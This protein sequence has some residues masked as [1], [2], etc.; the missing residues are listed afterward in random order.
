MITIGTFEQFAVNMRNDVA[1][2]ERLS[3]LRD[4]I[5]A[6]L[7][8]VGDVYPSENFAYATE[9]VDAAENLSAWLDSEVKDI[10]ARVDENYRNFQREIAIEQGLIED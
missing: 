6:T 4:K 3:A 5:D 8:E 7:K 2:I 1:A 10:K 9:F